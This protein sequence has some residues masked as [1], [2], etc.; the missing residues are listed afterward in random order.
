MQELYAGTQV[1]LPT[2]VHARTAV[3][4]HGTVSLS[5][6]LAAILVA[7]AGDASHTQPCP[8]LGR[9][10]GRARQLEVVPALRPLAAVAGAQRAARAAARHPAGVVPVLVLV[11]LQ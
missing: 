9:R 4:R 11:V 1:G 8:V 7:A 2:T 10:V 3:R 5:G 6:A